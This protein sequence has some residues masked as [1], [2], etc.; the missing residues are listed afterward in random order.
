[1]SPRV[2]KYLAISL[3]GLL[4]LL[5]VMTTLAGPAMAG[6]SHC[7]HQMDEPCPGHS[8]DHCTDHGLCGSGHCHPSY[9]SI[10]TLI[11]QAG[12]LLASL[13]P[14]AVE[15]SPSGLDPTSLYRPPRA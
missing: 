12:K 3:A 6:T 5:P 15:T 1:M 11:L 7:M 4:G 13:N 9:S 10:I 8:G 14:A 2:K